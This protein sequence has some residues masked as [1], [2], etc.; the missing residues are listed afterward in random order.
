MSIKTNLILSVAAAALLTTGCTTTSTAPIATATTTSKSITTAPVTAQKASDGSFT[1]PNAKAGTCY[2]KVIIPEKYKTITE[3]VLATQ[4]NTKLTIIPATYKTVTEKVLDTAASTK[5]VTVP[6]TY[7]TESRTITVSPAYTEWRNGLHP[8]ARVASS[9]LLASAKAAGVNLNAAKPGSCYYEF[10]AAPTFKTITEKILA[11]AASTKLIAQPAAFKTGTKRILVTPAST[12]LVK[13][14]AVYKTVTERVQVAPASKVWKET[15][16][17]DENCATPEMMCLVDVPAVYKTIT[18]QVVVKPETTKTIT[19]P[20]QYKTV[21]SN[22]LAAPATTKT[23]NIPATYKTLNKTVKVSDAKYVWSDSMMEKAG[24]S[25]TSAVICKVAI[26]AVTKTITKQVVATPASSKTITIPATYKTVQKTKLVTPATTKKTVIPATYKTI[27]KQVK[28][29]DQ[30]VKWMPVLCKSS[31][32]FQT[33]SKI[34]RAL[35]AAGFKTTVTGSLDAAT[36]AS[37]KAYQMKN[38]L[39]VSG[40]SIDTLK[41]LGVL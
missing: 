6:A 41:R 5:I 20:A 8:E 22:V 9:A 17:K 28:V 21:E 29:S 37:V 19:I 2:G 24:M 18:K 34:Q 35:T 14:P 31:M 30:A 16:C 12:K 3:K 10:Y 25:R 23:I 11:T 39:T 7:K 33:I 1:L 15:K 13:V 27:T 36:K 26:P 32:T 40:L 4:A 38:G